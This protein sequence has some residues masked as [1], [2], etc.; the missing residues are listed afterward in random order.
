MQQKYRVAAIQSRYYPGEPERALARV[1]ELIDEAASWGATLACLTEYVITGYPRPELAEPIPGPAIERLG[2][3]CR[4]H[5]M[6]LV[7]G[8]IMEKEGDKF[9]NTVALLGTDGQVIGKYRKINV[10]DWP[11]KRE[12]SRGVAEG[13]DIPIF[14][15]S[16]GRIGI[17][18][19]ADLDPAEPCRILALKGCDV[20]LAP[21]SC[22]GQWVDAHRYVAQCR[23]WEMMCYV[24]A[25]NPCGDVRL[26][27]DPTSYLGSSRIF[28]PMGEVIASCGEF[29]EGVA[30]VTV[31][32]KKVRSVKRD[33]EW[34]L[35]R[36][37]KA[38]EYLAKSL[39][40]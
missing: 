37:P 34:K 15:T 24:V 4:R 19:G 40:S 35:R 5:G 22:T 8:S 7:A 13:E 14:E 38:Y 36:F 1:E 6:H 17:L 31:D 32:L 25:P 2:A 20:L 23:S 9:Y 18:T 10:L 29:D 27:E 30:V 12:I 26:G 28:S 21:H 3:R 16:L 33:N 39:G 11:P